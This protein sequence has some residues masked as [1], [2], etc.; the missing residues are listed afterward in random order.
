MILAKKLQPDQVIL[1]KCRSN[2][3]IL[4]VFVRSSNMKYQVDFARVLRRMLSRKPSNVSHLLDT[5][6]M[7]PELRRYRWVAGWSGVWTSDL[8]SVDQGGRRGVTSSVHVLS[9]LVMSTA[10]GR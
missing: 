7:D 2:L 1:D 4:D 3:E 10:Q 8:N 9:D 6:P 5:D